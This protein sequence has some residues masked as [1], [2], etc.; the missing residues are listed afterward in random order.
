MLE[1]ECWMDVDRF[2]EGSIIMNGKRCDAPTCIV[3]NK[4]PLARSVELDVAGRTA[5]RRYGVQQFQPSRTA[6]YSKGADGSVRVFAYSI[7]KALT[8][9]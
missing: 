2:T 6:V 7:K 5:L 3:R 8:G 4:E 9:V 1:P